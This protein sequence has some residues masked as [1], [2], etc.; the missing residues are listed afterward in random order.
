MHRILLGGGDSLNKSKRVKTCLPNFNFKG[1]GGRGVS[2]RRR[3]GGGLEYQTK[4][5]SKLKMLKVVYQ[6]GD[7]K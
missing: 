6:M 3:K 2:A 5:A 4:T 1:G 7:T